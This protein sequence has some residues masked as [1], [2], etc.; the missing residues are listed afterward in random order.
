M[1]PRLP[2]LP[3]PKTKT[4]PTKKAK[5]KDGILLVSAERQ[6]QST[7][8][9]GIDPGLSG[10]IAGVLRGRLIFA[11]SLP[12]SEYE[13]WQLIRKIADSGYPN[14]HHQ[15]GIELISPGFRGT[16][17][18]SMAKLYGSYMQLRGFLTA[19]GIGFDTLSSKKWQASLGVPKLKTDSPDKWKRKLL[20][21]AKQLFPRQPCWAATQKT[22]LTYS[23]AILMANYLYSIRK[24]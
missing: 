18:S 19:A 23:D 2:N 12:D 10:G 8:Y 15:A 6:N 20:A 4:V 22:Q 5:P 1:P 24:D 11:Y 9:L 7:L 16:G 13:C 3:N 14:N 21:K 17:K